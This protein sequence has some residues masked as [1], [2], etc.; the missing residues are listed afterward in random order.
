MA[1]VAELLLIDDG[2]RLAEHARAVTPQTAAR[3]RAL[4]R[5]YGSC[6]TSE[7]IEDLE[8]LGFLEVARA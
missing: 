3:A 6:S 1:K 5:A 8:A 4:F 7:P 2:S